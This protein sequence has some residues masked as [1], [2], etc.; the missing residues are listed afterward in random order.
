[1]NNRVRIFQYYVHNTIWVGAAREE[2]GVLVILVLLGGADQS[3]LDVLEEGLAV[4]D[5][6]EGHTVHPVHTGT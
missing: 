3:V 5:G 4:T 6:S 1:M 2:E